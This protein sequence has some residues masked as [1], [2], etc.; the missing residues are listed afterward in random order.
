MLAERRGDLVNDHPLPVATTWNLS[1]E[2][3][4]HRNPVAADLLRACAFLAPDAIPETIMTQG[5]SQLGSQLSELGTDADGLDQ[6]VETL[7]AYSLV[8]RDAVQGTLSVH[9]LVQAVLK[10]QMTQEEQCQWAERMVKAVNV[11]FPFVEHRTWSQWEVMLLHAL[12]MVGLI[13][14]YGM[15]MPEAS[16]LLNQAAFYLYERARY[17]EAEPLYVRALAICEQQL[18]A[19]HPQTASSLNNLAALYYRQ[20]KYGEAEPVR[21]VCVKP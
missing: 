8:W 7:R 10:D 12:V 4:E 3:V 15:T 20:G 11:A 21:S 19:E 16:G 9:R 6:A 5:A 18:G 2:Q 14:Q 1:F 13:E 17:P